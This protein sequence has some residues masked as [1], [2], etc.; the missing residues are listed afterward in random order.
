MPARAARFGIA[1]LVQHRGN[2]AKPFAPFG[3]VRAQA[4]EKKY[5]PLRNAALTPN[6]GRTQPTEWTTEGT[7]LPI[8]AKPSE[9]PL[10]SDKRLEKSPIK[11]G[12]PAEPWP[13]RHN[14]RRGQVLRHFNA[15]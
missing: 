12:R 7:W 14:A 6:V 11:L 10:I 4:A 13:M 1:Q 9:N 3:I 5:L 2:E 8:R 15:T